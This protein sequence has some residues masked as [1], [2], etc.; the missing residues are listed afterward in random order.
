[1]KEPISIHT[2]LDDRDVEKLR[3]GDRVSINGTVYTAR[4][5][6]HKR[7]FDLLKRGEGLPFDLAGQVIYYVGPTPARPG[8]VIGAA[9]PTTAY[10]MDAYAPAL[11]A[12]GLKGMIGKGSRGENVIDALKRYKAVY[13][14]ATG[15]AGAL[16]S[17][18]IKKVEMV[19]YEDLGTEA[20]RR[21]VV[22]DFPAIVANDVYGGDL[23]EE[24][25]EKYRQR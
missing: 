10:R 12:E 18:R 14:A 25:L 13:F 7:L 3:A 1:L 23:Y 9:G 6:A 20:I 22:E 19:A 4:D 16:I 17:K 2:P 11:I 24:G 21:L 15:G 8:A 5:A